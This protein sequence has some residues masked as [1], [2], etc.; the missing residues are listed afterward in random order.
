MKYNF[1]ILFINNNNNFKLIKA[2][3]NK[4]YF[5]LNL[6]NKIKIKWIFSLNNNNKIISLILIKIN[7]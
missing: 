1:K 4:S 7:K 3:N 5:N 6:I 2:N